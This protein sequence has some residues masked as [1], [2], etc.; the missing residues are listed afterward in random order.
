MTCTQ[1]QN[2]CGRVGLAVARLGSPFYCML[3]DILSDPRTFHIACLRRS[4]AFGLRLQPE[5]DKPAYG[6]GARHS[7]VLISPFVN[8]GQLL[9][10]PAH[11]EL[12][13]PAGRRRSAAFLFWGTLN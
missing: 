11:A 10:V 7:A 2:F 3:I 4:S 1:R 9:I 12:Y 13:P 8:R 5:L 6:F